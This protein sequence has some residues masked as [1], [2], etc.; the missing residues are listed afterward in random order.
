MLMLTPALHDLL[1][2]LRTDRKVV[3]LE[4]QFDI[5]DARGMR[6]TTGFLQPL[7]LDRIY[8]SDSTNTSA[9]ASAK[10]CNS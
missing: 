1:L 6:A 3:T 5:G 10:I 9:V 4:C 2:H 7:E 8:E